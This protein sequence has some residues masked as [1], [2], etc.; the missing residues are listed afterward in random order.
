MPGI[1]QWRGLMP[2]QVIVE[3]NATVDTYGARTYTTCATY[4]A[5]IQGPS[6]FLHQSSQQE[7]VSRQT[8]YL[9]TAD[10][11]TTQDRITLPSAFEIT[12]PPILDV[13]RVSDRFGTHHVKVLCG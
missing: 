7:R 8:V 2:Y 4:A 10:P 12:Q 1:T 6:R 5:A 3:S 13:Q 11:I 9:A